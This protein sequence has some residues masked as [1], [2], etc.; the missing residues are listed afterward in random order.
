MKTGGGLVREHD[1]RDVTERIK[2]S[3]SATPSDMYQTMSVDELIY[4][5]DYLTT[6][7]NDRR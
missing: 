4:L 5:V 1:T 3:L 6:L 7:K 2:Q